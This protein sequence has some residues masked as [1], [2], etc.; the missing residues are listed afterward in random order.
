MCSRAERT[1]T[2]KVQDDDGTVG[3]DRIR[4]R[5]DDT[6]DE[7]DWL[8]SR[9]VSSLSDAELRQREERYGSILSQREEEERK[10]RQDEERQRREEEEAR[11]K[12]EEAQRKT[13]EE[14]RKMREKEERKKREEQER[15]REE[16]EE[17]KEREEAQRKARE[18]EE[19]KEEQ[20]K[21][22]EEQERKKREEEKRE[23]E[24]HI[25]AGEAAVAFA[26][27]RLGNG[28]IE[29]AKEARAKAALEYGQAK[30]DRTSEIAVRIDVKTFQDPKGHIYIYIHTCMLVLTSLA[31]CIAMVLGI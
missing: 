29:E 4:V 31:V 22:R 6:G 25:V 3:H 15:K 12:R 9:D 27:E 2:G 14:E 1:R 16:D 19:R 26:R 13:R 24:T 7:S 8:G 28:D 20:R 17:R 23:R 18:E 21:K 5:W 10:K 11:K 30:E